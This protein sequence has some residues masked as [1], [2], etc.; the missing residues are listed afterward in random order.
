MPRRTQLRS[1]HSATPGSFR[2]H[3]PEFDYLK[4]RAECAPRVRVADVPHSRWRLRRRSTRSAGSRQ[5]GPSFGERLLAHRPADAHA[6]LLHA[7]DERQGAATHCG[8]HACGVLRP[9]AQTIKLW[10]CGEKPEKST[11]YIRCSE[12]FPASSLPD[13]PSNS[14][15]QLAVP[16]LK[17]GNKS[18]FAKP[19]RLFANAHAYHINRCVSGVACGRRMFA[20][21]APC[22]A[23]R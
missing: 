15:G 21:S 10:R 11:E 19:R 1:A 13:T 6:R 4:V 5:E 16:R 2:S 14:N 3:E 8:A 20:S 12:R 9:L 17:S 22:P 18:F 23:S 7:D